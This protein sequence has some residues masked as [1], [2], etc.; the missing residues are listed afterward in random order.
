M[1]TPA[2]D[3]YRWPLCRRG[4]SPLPGVLT[5]SEDARKVGPMLLVSQ[6]SCPV[7]SGEM[8]RCT[9]GTRIRRK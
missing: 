2:S 1:R 6:L 5:A 8:A 9:I 4:V 3:G 7:H